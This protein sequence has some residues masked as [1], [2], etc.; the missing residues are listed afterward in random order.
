MDSLLSASLIVFT[1]LEKLDFNDL[2][3]AMMAS[4]NWEAGDILFFLEFNQNLDTGI[5]VCDGGRAEVV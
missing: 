5:E 1:A 3:K 2:F 4:K